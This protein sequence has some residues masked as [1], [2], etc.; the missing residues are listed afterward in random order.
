MPRHPNTFRHGWLLLFL[1]LLTLPAQANSLFEQ[2]SSRFGS[3]LSNSSKTEFL[4]PEQAFQPRTWVEG[5]QIFVV[6]TITPSYYL[7]RD[8]LTLTLEEGSGLSVTRLDFPPSISHE[9]E[10]FG[11]VEIYY[12][13]VELAAQLSGSTDLENLQLTLGY[14]GCADAGL[15]YPPERIQQTVSLAKLDTS[16]APR[17]PAMQPVAPPASSSSQ[18]ADLLGSGQLWMTLGLF[19]LAGLGL[20]FTPCVLP[21]LPILST[22]ILGKGQQAETGRKRRGLLLSSA[23]V[24]GMALTYAAIGALMGLF[25]ASMNLQ[26]ALQSP[27]LLV[28]FAGL[29]LLLALALFGL[30][31][32]KLPRWLDDRLQNLQQPRS[33]TLLNVALMGVLSTLVVSPCLTAPLAGA[34]AFIATTGNATTGALALF[35]MGL[36]MGV[37]LILTGTF[38]AHWLPKAGAWMNQ[39]KAV[40]GVLMLAMA[41]WMLER[42]LPGNLALA[43][44]GL[45]ALGSGVFLGGL[46]LQAT[47]GWHKLR[48]TAGLTLIIYGASL[49]LGALAGNSSLLQPLA[50]LGKASSENQLVVVDVPKIQQLD[51]LQQILAL[52]PGPVLVDLY[53]DWCISCKVMESKVFPRQEVQQQLQGIAR[54]KL[55]LTRIS[56][57]VRSWLDEN[58][59][60]GPPT[61]MFF[62]QG[63]EWRDWRLQGEVNATDLRQHLLA[64][65]QARN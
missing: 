14:Q 57:E 45:L 23:Y 37:P 60:F 31:E 38:G 65:N 40:F 9:D 29:F 30:F 15:C 35:A 5:S 52:T 24:A 33:G 1:L 41:L 18:L 19:F 48:L 8:R 17:T 62:V 28:P 58:Q 3:W 43:L 11:K 27:W 12:D 6:W 22:I 25:G 26:A 50:G 53:A 34:L 21:M 39:V 64:F 4:R 13:Q 61:L 10:F 32:L 2:G 42:L 20:T 36:G 54:Y 49:L 47:G 16:A 59:L 7:Y 46:N 56:P 63:Q 44:W 55:D 51:E